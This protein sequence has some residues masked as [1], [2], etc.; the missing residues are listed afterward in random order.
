MVGHGRWYAGAIERAAFAAVFAM[1]II[2]TAGA[3]A[4]HQDPGDLDPSFGHRGKVR[5]GFGPRAFESARSVVIGKQ[6]RIVAAGQRPFAVARYKPSGR[7]DGSFS[8][9]GKV[10][11]KFGSKFSGANAVTIMGHG[12][13]VAAGGATSRKAHPQQQRRLAIARYKPNGHLDH[14]FSHDGKVVLNLGG[15]SATETVYAVAIDSQGRTVLGGAVPVAGDERGALVRLKQNGKLDRSFANGGVVDMAQG[16]VSSLAIDSQ[17]RIVVG[18]GQSLLRYEPNGQPDTAFGAGG[19]AAL[20]LSASS[21]A[22]DSGGRIVVTGPRGKSSSFAVERFTRLGNPDMSFGNG[23]TATI[24]FHRKSGARSVA[25]DSKKRIVVFGHVLKSE[26]CCQF[27]TARFRPNGAPDLSFGHKGQVETKFGGKITLDA[28][29][30]VAID[31]RDRIVAAGGARHGFA[32]V[33][34]IG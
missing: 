31:D 32:L 21:L 14:S 7:L 26:K 27:A 17:G 5:T 11:T 13:V 9:D 24:S 25:I 22:L 33:R 28:P 4:A 18:A 6:G 2:S 10:K 29:G 34:Y 16:T 30:G 3:L 23:G 1:V 19:T 15:G 20:N 8:K 12:K